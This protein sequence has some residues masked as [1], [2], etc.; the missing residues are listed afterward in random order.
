VPTVPFDLNDPDWLRRS[1]RLLGNS[2]LL[3]AIVAAQREIATAEL[4]LR[5]VHDLVCS[6]APQ[7]TGVEGAAVGLVEGDEL[8]FHAACGMLTSVAQTR[9]SVPIGLP[10]RGL[11]AEG[12]LACDS[13]S[14]AQI[15]DQISRRVGARCEMDVPLLDIEGRGIGLLMIASSQPHVFDDRACHTLELLSSFVAAAVSHAAA[16]QRQTEDK[17]RTEDALQLSERVAD[18][19][20]QAASIAHEIKN[21]LESMGNLLYL[22]QQ[23][24]SLDQTARTYV[25]WLQQELSRAIHI[26]QQT[27]DFSKQSSQRLTVNVPGL[28]DKVLDFYAHKIR[29][30]RISVN[31]RYGSTVEVSGFPGELRQVF[32]NLLVNAM[33]AVGIGTGRLTLHAFQASHWQS[34]VAGVRVVIADNG[35]GIHPDHRS[36]L[37]EPFFTTKEKGTG[38]GLWV[39]KRLV[40]KHGGAIRF[41]SR[42]HPEAGGTC[43]A[44]FLPSNGLSAQSSHD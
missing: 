13:D 18:V 21:P 28:L 15:K 17:K 37:F 39:T 26:S 36:K 6:Q 3:G 32:T 38:L 41:R 33:E 14:V 42:F 31:K 9:L 29:Y 20:R 24:S 27:L 12:E 34:R 2:D 40:H 1:E 11:P 7:L 5:Q 8:V 19:G 22:L 30:K 43:F 10:T 23:N 4:N 25:Q 44:V 35:Q 16:F